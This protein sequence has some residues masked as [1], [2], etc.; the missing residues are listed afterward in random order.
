MNLFFCGCV[1]KKKHQ[2]TKNNNNKNR[3]Q[4]V[5]Y[6]EIERNFV[7]CLVHSHTVPPSS[8]YDNSKSLV[9]SECNVPKLEDLAREK[10]LYWSHYFQR[11]PTSVSLKREK[12]N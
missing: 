2:Q 5:I 9:E 3:T 8:R 6:S 10:L 1:F 4:R 7:T 11:K 12:K